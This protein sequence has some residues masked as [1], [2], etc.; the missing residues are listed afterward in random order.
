MVGQ[1]LDPKPL[2]IEAVREGDT[3]LLRLTAASLVRE[4]HCLADT[5]NPGA[6]PDRGMVTLRAGE[7]AEIRIS[8]AGDAD[9]AAFA[10]A[11]RYANDL[12]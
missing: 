5:V 11:V 8:A 2:R 10:A 7:T 9:P 6:R 4:A 12:L 1:R 3:V